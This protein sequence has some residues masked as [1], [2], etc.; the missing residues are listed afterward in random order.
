MRVFAFDVSGSSVCFMDDMI[1]DAKAQSMSDKDMAVF[2]DTSGVSKPQL[3]KSVDIESLCT[4]SGGDGLDQLMTWAEDRF[5]IPQD[6]LIIYHDLMAPAEFI[7]RAIVSRYTVR[8]RVLPGT[9]DSSLEHLREGGV[10]YEFAR[11]ASRDDVGT[12]GKAA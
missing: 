10:S 9:H 11:I 7:D 3:L 8:F 2:F 12:W 1:A 6:E 5:L 4:H